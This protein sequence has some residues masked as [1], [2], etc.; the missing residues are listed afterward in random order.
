[1]QKALDVSLIGTACRATSSSIPGPHSCGPC[2]SSPGSL[3]HV[4]HG[5][6]QC[7]GPQQGVLLVPGS[8]GEKDPIYFL[9]PHRAGLGGQKGGEGRRG[10][11]GV[12]VV[13]RQ[14]REGPSAPSLLPS[15][16]GL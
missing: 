12:E 14:S 7:S 15:P 16:S 9:L 8:P 10:T 4:S 2:P 5:S 13:G 11:R 6:G 3:A 1:M